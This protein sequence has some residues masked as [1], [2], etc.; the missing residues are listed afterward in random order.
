MTN[1]SLLPPAVT[2][3][4]LVSL[5]RQTP[6][7]WLGLKIA[8]LLLVLEG[9]RP[10]WIAEVLGVTRMS[11]HR[12]VQAVQQQGAA[13]LASKPRPGRPSQLTARLAQR[14]RR[15]LERSPQAAGLNRVRWD[16][17]TLVEYL[18]QHGG[19]TLTVRQA[20]NWLHR[21]GYQLKRASHVYLQARAA[22]AQRFRRALK[23]TAPPGPPR[24][25]GLSG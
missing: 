3:Q 5:A 15:H 25:R 20:Q 24:D 16:G 7:A 21:L 23:K 1:L 10:S 12:W 11:L 13:A 2:K 18:K 9:Q 14:L 19:L 8:A 4:R 6:G 17:P 22:D